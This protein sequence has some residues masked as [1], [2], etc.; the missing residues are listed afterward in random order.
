M[1]S[2]GATD[3]LGKY[4]SRLAVAEAFI[5]GKIDNYEERFVSE[6]VNSIT[7]ETAHIRL[8][9]MGMLDE[10]HIKKVLKGS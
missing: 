8:R 3:L 4:S 2:I 10:G 5:L 7:L 6:L 9:A 1:A